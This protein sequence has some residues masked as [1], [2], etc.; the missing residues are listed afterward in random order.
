MS[1]LMVDSDSYTMPRAPGARTGGRCFSERCTEE[2]RCKGLAFPG[3]SV[4]SSS[5][6]SSYSSGSVFLN[7]TSQVTVKDIL[8]IGA[9]L[10]L[11]YVHSLSDSH[12]STD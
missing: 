11:G 3:G 2:Y 1:V 8:D 12:V 6:L 5:F 7:F 9:K 4:F 10:D